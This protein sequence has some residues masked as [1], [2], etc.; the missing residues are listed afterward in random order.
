[1]QGSTENVVEHILTMAPGTMHYSIQQA[2]LREIDKPSFS[3]AFPP[4]SDASWIKILENSPAVRKENDRLEYLGDALMYA[5]LG[6]QVYKQIPRGDPGLYTVR[7][8]S[9]HT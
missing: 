9:F 6:E 7:P 1:M 8:P 2:I 5:T 3:G 4:L